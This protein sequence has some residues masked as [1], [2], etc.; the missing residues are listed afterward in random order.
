M[1]LSKTVTYSVK[2]SPLFR[3]AIYNFAEDNEVDHSELTRIFWER[4]IAGEVMFPTYFQLMKSYQNIAESFLDAIRCVKSE[5]VL[6]LQTL[7]NIICRTKLTPKKGIK[8][9][10]EMKKYLAQLDREIE[11]QIPQ[12]AKIINRDLKKSAELKKKKADKQ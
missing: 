10:D 12:V 3:Q 5:R 7:A 9:P 6:L 8:C 1:K 11:L 2:V 4:M